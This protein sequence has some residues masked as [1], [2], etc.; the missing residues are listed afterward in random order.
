[1]R[2]LTRAASLGAALILAACGTLPGRAPTGA[3]DEAAWQ[4]RNMQ[5]ASLQDWSLSGK[6]GFANG[7]DSGSGGLEWTQRA[8]MTTLD[9]HGPLGAGGVHMEG[10]AD[11]L[12]VRTSR[13]DDFTTQDPEADLGA[14]L[15]QPLPV[16]SLRYWILGMPDPRDGFSKVSDARGEL[17]SLDQSG[18]HVEYQEY[19]DVSGYSLPTRLTLTR[20]EVRIK[21]VVSDWVL[22]AVAP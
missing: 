2:H 8:G 18:W 17:M 15:H 1:M 16:L 11:E 22:P 21:M 6:V 19:T 4:Q 7:R 13:G 9:F 14:R 3:P 10:G 12:H 5:L 20:G